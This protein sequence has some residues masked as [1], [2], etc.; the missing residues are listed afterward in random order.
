ME[1]IVDFKILPERLRQAA[2]VVTVAVASPADSHTEEVIER[3]IAEQFARFILVANAAKADIARRLAADYL[4]R[5]L[6][7]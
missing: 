1:P 6:D 7:A 4:D 5:C 3:S 2:Q